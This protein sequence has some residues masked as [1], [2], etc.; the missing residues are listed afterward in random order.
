L[1]RDRKEA[2]QEEKKKEQSIRK[3]LANITEGVI[4]SCQG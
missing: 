3:K 1:L 4:I 2:S